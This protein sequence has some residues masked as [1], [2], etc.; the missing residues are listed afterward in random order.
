MEGFI[1]ANT[2][3]CENVVENKDGNISINNIFNIMEFNKDDGEGFCVI[4]FLNI[5]GNINYNVHLYLENH[6]GGKIRYKR[7]KTHSIAN[8]ESSMNSIV[9]IYRFRTKKLI[10]QP[11]RYFATIYKTEQQDQ[12]KIDHKDIMKSDNLIAITPLEV[13]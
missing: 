3:I 1:S 9:Q 7:L 8:E 12:D 11:G 5:M 10:S 2:I 6:T 4:M 13:K